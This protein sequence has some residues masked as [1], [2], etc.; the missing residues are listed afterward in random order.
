[1][2]HSES[3]VVSCTYTRAPIA[4]ASLACL[5]A[6]QVESSRRSVACL[7]AA[8]GALLQHSRVN[9]PTLEVGGV[10][11]CGASIHIH[12][13]HGHVASKLEAVGLL[14]CSG[15]HGC[16]CRSARRCDAMRSRGHH[17][18][19]ATRT[20][21][22][23][24]HVALVTP[25][26]LNFVGRTNNG[27][28]DLPGAVASW[29]GQDRTGSTVCIVLYHGELLLPRTLEGPGQG[30][31]AITGHRSP[32]VEGALVHN[33][34]LRTDADG[35]EEDV[36]LQHRYSIPVC[37]RAHRILRSCGAGVVL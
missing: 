28:S 29:A 22:V 20:R 13:V 27:C 18:Q 4:R 3:R 2:S 35:I 19:L 33:S 11:H 31:G 25:Y 36:I 9:V 1:M 30:Q 17:V 6:L 37:V 24:T 23:P 10:R 7:P 5:L 26:T 21:T 15:R 34:N 32:A 8:P 14:T 12:T 16:A